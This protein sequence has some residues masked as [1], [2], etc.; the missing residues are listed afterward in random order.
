MKF[1][2]LSLKSLPDSA[3]LVYVVVFAGIVIAALYYAFSRVDQKQGKESNKRR[4]SPKG[5]KNKKA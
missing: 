1:L 4:K 2:G 3:K 5:D